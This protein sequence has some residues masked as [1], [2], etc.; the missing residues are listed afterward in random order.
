[1]FH[2]GYLVGAVDVESAGERLRELV[3]IFAA[4]VGAA[5]AGAEEVGGCS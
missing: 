2:D 5:D 4:V 3:M 1:M